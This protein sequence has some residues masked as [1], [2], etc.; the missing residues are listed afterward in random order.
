MPATL[1]SPNKHDEPRHVVAETVRLQVEALR[2]ALSF[3]EPL[4]PDAQQRIGALLSQLATSKEEEVEEVA[5]SLVEIL[6]S[7]WT[8]NVANTLSIDEWIEKAS[9][10]ESRRRLAS[11]KRAFAESVKTILSERGLSQDDLAE[12]LGIRQSTLSEL[13]SGKFKPQPKTLKKLADA[14]ECT[15]HDLWGNTK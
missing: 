5:V 8:A 3:F 9:T 6:D 15:I 7:E 4:S 1:D 11:Q 12:R 13:I 2:R 14:L 10:E